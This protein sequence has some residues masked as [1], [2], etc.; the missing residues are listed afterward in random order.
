MNMTNAANIRLDS[1]PPPM[2]DGINIKGIALGV[3]ES[4]L[5]TF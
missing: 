4:K 3:T 1:R 2:G 5:M